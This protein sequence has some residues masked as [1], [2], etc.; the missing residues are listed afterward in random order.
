MPARRL[1]YFVGCVA[2]RWGISPV[3]FGA[4]WGSLPKG[5]AADGSA[6]GDM[7]EP[8]LE[9]EMTSAWPCFEILCGTLYIIH[10]PNCSKG[11][12]LRMSGA[13]GHQRGLRAQRRGVVVRVDGEKHVG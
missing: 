10:R 7:S 13:M 11:M 6:R 9:R 3:H 8:R 5:V 12:S 4:A 2:L 1:P